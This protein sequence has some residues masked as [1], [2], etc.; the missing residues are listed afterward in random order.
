M[1]YEGEYSNCCGAPIIWSDICS[2][3]KEH[4]KPMEDDDE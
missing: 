1:D 3:C 2:D 4:C